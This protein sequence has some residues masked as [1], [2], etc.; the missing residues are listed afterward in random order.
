MPAFPNVFAPVPFPVAF[1]PNV[2]ARGRRG[3]PLHDD[4]RRRFGHDNIFRRWFL[5][6]INAL[7]GLT[8]PY[9]NA[10]TD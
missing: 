3:A 10:T 1:D 9:D 4:R 7:D 2:A 8:F 6:D 5:H